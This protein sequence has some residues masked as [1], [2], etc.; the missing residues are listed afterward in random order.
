VHNVVGGVGIVDI[1]LLEQEAR[2]S[3]L[4]VCEEPLPF[5]SRRSRKFFPEPATRIAHSV[6]GAI[7]L[8]ER[9]VTH[10]T[11]EAPV[12]APV[13]GSEFVLAVGK[14]NVV[15]IRIVE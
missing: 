15:K 2:Y 9:P 3:V 8:I 7:W 6:C 14:K 1:R 5:F 13:T 11:T 12:R 4:L 10:I